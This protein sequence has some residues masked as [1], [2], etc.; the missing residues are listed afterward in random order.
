LAINR[1][2]SSLLH[3]LVLSSPI[4]NKKAS[5]KRGCTNQIPLTIKPYPMPSSYGMISNISIDVL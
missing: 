2:D 5:P 4:E 1:T 3:R